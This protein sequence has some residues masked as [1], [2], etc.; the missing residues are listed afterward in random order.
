MNVSK[1]GLYT[2]LCWL[3]VVFLCWFTL[4]INS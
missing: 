2:L 3:I 1:D 4:Y